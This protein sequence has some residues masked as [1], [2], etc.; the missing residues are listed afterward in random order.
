MVDSPNAVPALTYTIGSLSV[1]GSFLGM[2]YE[3]IVYGIV[4]GV[5]FLL[6][7]APKNA[8]NLVSTLL[9]SAIVAGL[10]APVL[11]EVLV[12]DGGLD[13]TN[14][15]TLQRFFAFVL[16]GSW[17]IL[18]PILLHL[19]GKFKTLNAK[20][21]NVEFGTEAVPAPKETLHKRNSREK[22]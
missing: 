21:P 10:G 17:L 6:F 4:G 2:P 18:L 8:H 11:A 14:P 12:H 9:G 7:N 15:L 3:G 13:N 16:G 5:M 19:I 20:F 1:A 22:D